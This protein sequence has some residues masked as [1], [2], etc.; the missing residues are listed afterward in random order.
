MSNLTYGD[1]RRAQFPGPGQL[2]Y[3][4]HR[5]HHLNGVMEPPPRP[6]PVV[7][8]FSP[9]RQSHKFDESVRLA[10]LQTQN[11]YAESVPIRLSTQRSDSRARSIEAM[12]MTIPFI[13]KIKLLSRI[14]PALAPAGHTSPV[15][16]VR[17][18]V[19]AVEGADIK[20]VQQVGEFIDEYLRQEPECL[21]KTWHVPSESGK[22]IDT[23]DSKMTDIVTASTGNPSMEDDPFLGYLHTIQLW[24][25]KSAEMTKFIT[26]APPPATTTTVAA[27]ACEPASAIS[28][29]TVPVIATDSP[30]TNIGKDKAPTP[31]A[32]LPCGFSLSTSDHYASII[33]INDAYA[34]VD[35]W[36]WM[37]T[38]WRGIIGPDLTVYV[39]SISENDAEAMA[40]LTRWGA[41]ECRKDCGAVIVRVVIKG[42][43]RMVLLAVPR[44]RMCR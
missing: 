26:T 15:H 6:S 35:H 34:P 33:P 31:I 23:I 44:G 9:V 7:H 30:S 40:E 8:P 42:E 17:G 19:I 29:T 39:R 43:G 25:Q 2:A 5:P 13:N 32:L 37:A 3:H 41:V 1:D 11:Y 22:E 4:N 10:P 24:H 16:E 14:S 28:H 20:L 18:V 21:V 27:P 12:I 38:L 36:Q